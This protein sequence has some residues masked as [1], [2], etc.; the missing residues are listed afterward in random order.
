MSSL[1]ISK[2]QIYFKQLFQLKVGDG[3]HLQT[4][5]QEKIEKLSIFSDYVHQCQPSHELPLP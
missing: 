2:L 4:Y 5:Y 1:E 3:S